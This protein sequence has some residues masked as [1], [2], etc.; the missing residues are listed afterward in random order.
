MRDWVD[1][2]KR[3]FTDYITYVIFI[4]SSHLYSSPVSMNE[5]GAAWVADC[6]VFSFLVNGFMEGAMAG[7]FTS[8]HQG[9]LVGRKDI[10]PDLDQ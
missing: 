6:P 8:N 9:V 1:E 3:C 5:M 7:V 10:A 4:N 2:L